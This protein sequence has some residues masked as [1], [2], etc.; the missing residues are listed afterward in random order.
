M[1]AEENPP[2]CDYE[3]SDY[4]SVFWEEGGR[5]YE[6]QVEAIAL[7]RLL[8]DSGKLLLETGAGAGRNTPR[9]QGFENIV[10]LD[11]SLSQ[12]QLAQERLGIDHRYRYVAADVYHLPFIP[13]T[14]DT[15]TMI[16]T[17]HHMADAPA[18]LRQ[19][20]Q[21]LQPDGIFLLEYA[22]KKNLKAILRYA[23]RK[24]DWSPFTLEPIEFAEL[25]Y[26]F[27]P[28]AV[29][30]WL[31]DCQFEVERQLTVSHYRIGILKRLVPHR[32]LVGMDSLAQLTGDWFQ[33]S[34]SVFVRSRAAG[35]TQVNET[36]SLFCCPTCGTYPLMEQHEVVCCD[37]CS[38]QWGI[39]NGIYDFRESLT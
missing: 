11:Y 37:S 25:N 2:I 33:L 13:G 6:D 15:V 26:D 27:H 3:G 24:Q 8:P 21:V 7:K 20:R 18:A 5:A 35:K 30:H 19:V 34:P 1:P 22:N 10:L 9:Y 23:L 17:L 12:L 31:R 14:F 4:Q 16:R 36:G 28:R 32:L 29:T 38:N 39:V